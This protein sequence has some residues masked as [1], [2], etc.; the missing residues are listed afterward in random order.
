MSKSPEVVSRDILLRAGIILERMLPNIV[1]T[2]GPE[3]IGKPTITYVDAADDD[4]A[5]EQINNRLFD[6]PAQLDA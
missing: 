2:G 4:K 6:H 5:R 1:K 3:Y